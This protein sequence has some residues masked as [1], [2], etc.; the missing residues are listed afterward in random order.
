[1]PTL[2]GTVASLSYVQCFLYFVSFSVNVSIFHSTWLDIFWTD[3]YIYNILLKNSVRDM[4]HEWVPC[5]D[6]AANHQLPIAT[7][8]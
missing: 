8:F 4:M 5:C 1:M 7:A 2:K 6:E 3:H